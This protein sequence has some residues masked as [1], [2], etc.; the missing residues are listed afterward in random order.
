MIDGLGWQVKF[1]REAK[2]ELR[3]L[4]MGCRGLYWLAQLPSLWTTLAK[5][6]GQGNLK[7]VNLLFEAL[8]GCGRFRQIS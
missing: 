1:S 4:A 8:D 5:I 2:A 3:S 6:G 7:D